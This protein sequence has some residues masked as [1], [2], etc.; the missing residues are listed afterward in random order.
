MMRMVLV[1]ILFWC[2]SCKCVIET[3]IEMFIDPLHAVRGT[4]SRLFVIRG[5]SNR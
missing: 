3:V 2:Y 5:I 4:S 1:I